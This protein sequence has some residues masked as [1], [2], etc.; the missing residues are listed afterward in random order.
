ML[1]PTPF[2]P[3]LTNS[4]TLAVTNATARG[5]INWPG[6]TTGSQGPHRGAGTVRIFNA[7]SETVWIK[8]GDVTVVATLNDMPIPG[9]AVEV[10]S[11]GGQDYV[12]AISASGSGNLYATPGMGS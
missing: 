10:F 4:T 11:T 3:Y 8:F 2:A 12:A 1:T 6:A 5:Q 9:G 7:L